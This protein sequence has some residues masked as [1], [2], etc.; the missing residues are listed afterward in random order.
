MELPDG[1]TLEFSTQL[2]EAILGIN[3][4]FK[5]VSEMLVGSVLNAIHDGELK[6]FCAENVIRCG[7]FNTGLHLSAYNGARLVYNL[8]Q[9][10]TATL[11]RQQFDELGA[12]AV[13]QW[14][15]AK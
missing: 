3:Q 14:F 11:S 1:E 8:E 9:F 10:Q 4:R 7:G 2:R 13:T 12:D 15:G 6:A 5:S